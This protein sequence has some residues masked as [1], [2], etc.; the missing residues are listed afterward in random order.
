MKPEVNTSAAE[1]RVGE[2][3]PLARRDGVLVEETDDETLVYD[4]RSHQAHCLNR[5]AALVWRSSDGSTHVPE[6]ARRLAHLGLPRDEAV[7][8]MALSRLERAGLMEGPVRMPGTRR[9]FSRKEVLRVLGMTAGFGMILPAV[10]SISAP[11]AAQ[12]A[13]CTPLA[14]CASL[15][16]PA[17]SGLPICE[18][19]TNCCK[20]QGKCR[21]RAC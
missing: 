10:T 21:V 18:S 13:S 6:M 12:A 11:L 16:P 7:I 8:W 20:A 19:R 3:A 5:S 1:P 9:S 4:L 15:T 17:C 14:Q 2:Q